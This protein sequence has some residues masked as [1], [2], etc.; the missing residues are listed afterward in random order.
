MDVCWT[1]GRRR[2]VVTRSILTF[3]TLCIL[4]GVVK[5]QV[6]QG[7]GGGFGGN[8]G[9]GINQGTFGGGGGFDQNIQPPGAGS[10]FTGTGNNVYYG[11]KS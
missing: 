7:P 4:I 10:L 11:G 1:P 5:A 6:G 3:T 9:G 2:F 8:I